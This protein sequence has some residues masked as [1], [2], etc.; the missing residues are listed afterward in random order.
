MSTPFPSGNQS[1]YCSYTNAQTCG[2]NWIHYANTQVDKL[3]A[4]GAA[5]TSA[6][7]E[8]SDFN[9]ADKILWSDMATLPLYQTPQYFAWSS[10]YGNVIPNTSDVG[11]PWNANLWGLKAS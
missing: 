5:A 4:S 10:S 8:A 9:A 2:Q 7:T 11:I 6:A 1:I 3:M